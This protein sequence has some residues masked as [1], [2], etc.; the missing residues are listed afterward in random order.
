MHRSFFRPFVADPACASSDP[1]HHVDVGRF[2][3][4][5]VKSSVTVPVRAEVRDG[6]V[7]L[8]S[9]GWSAELWNHRPEYVDEA[10]RGTRGVAEWAPEWQVLL[11]PGASLADE[12]TV[13]TLAD[14]D[15][16]TECVVD[17]AL[18]PA[19]LRCFRGY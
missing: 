7:R 5:V 4:A 16:C 10:L 9:D 17:G 18:S 14:R 3:M 19:G 6:L 1:G 15:E 13:F 12:R 2:F 8:D 11:V